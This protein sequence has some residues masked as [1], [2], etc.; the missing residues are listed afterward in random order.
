MEHTLIPLSVVYPDVYFEGEIP[1]GTH[2][3]IESDDDQLSPRKIKV[4]FS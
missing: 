4:S 1:Q 3:D 2:Y